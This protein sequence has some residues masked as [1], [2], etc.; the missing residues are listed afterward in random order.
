MKNMTKT[1]TDIEKQNK[2]ILCHEIWCPKKQER[3]VAGTG[4][5]MDISSCTKCQKKTRWGWTGPS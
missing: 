3:Q 4:E 5:A 1:K 2:E